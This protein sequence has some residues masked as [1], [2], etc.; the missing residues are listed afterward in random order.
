MNID[1]ATALYALGAATGEELVAAALSA[2]SGTF[3]SDD[4]AC[5]AGMNN[6]ALSEAGPLFEAMIEQ[7]G[8]KILPKEKTV[9]DL[10]RIYAEQIVS[11]KVSPIRGA[12]SFGWLWDKADCPDYLSALFALSTDADEERI[13]IDYASDT[14]RAMKD[15]AIREYENRI[16]EEAR[17]LLALEEGSV[18]LRGKRAS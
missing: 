10:A 12:A 4:A 15:A 8:R 1:K 17:A 7:L 3:T 18:A 5:L 11:G 16:L 14:L 6:P 9:W 2:I 13:A